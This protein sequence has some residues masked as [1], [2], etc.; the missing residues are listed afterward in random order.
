MTLSQLALNPNFLLWIAGVATF[1]TLVVLL[2]T[3]LSTMKNEEPNINVTKSAQ[4]FLGTFAMSWS[5]CMILTGIFSF[6]AGLK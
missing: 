2:I 4:L 3:V 6:L 1:V 5:F